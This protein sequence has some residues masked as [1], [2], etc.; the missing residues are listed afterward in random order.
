M[1]AELRENIKNFLLN[2]DLC[3]M[4]VLRYLGEKQQE[5]Y[6]KLFEEW[7]HPHEPQRKRVQRTT[8]PSCL[9]ILDPG[10]I[11]E[12]FET[13]ADAVALSSCTFDDFLLS[14][15]VPAVTLIRQRLVYLQLKSKFEYNF[16]EDSLATVKDCVKYVI[17]SL[18]EDEFKVQ[19]CPAASFQVNIVLKGEFREAEHQAIVKLSAKPKKKYKRNQKEEQEFSTKAITAFLQETSDEDFIREFKF[20]PE[21]TSSPDA[22]TATCGHNQIYFAGRYCKFSRELSQ[23]PW[24]IDGARRMKDSVEELITNVVKR[25]VRCGRITFSSSGREDVDVR[26][27]G[28]GRPFLLEVWS[29]KRIEWSAE[30]CAEIEEEINSSTSDISVNRFQ[31]INREQIK[32]L[33]TGEENKRKFYC[34]YCVT[35]KDTSTVDFSKL[36]SID[37][38]VLKQNTP[39]RVLHRRTAMVRER[40]IHSASVEIQDANHFKLTVCTQAGTYVK[41]FVHGDMGRTLPNVRTILAEQVDIEALDVTHVDL[42]WPPDRVAATSQQQKPPEPTQQQN[43]PEQIQAPRQL[44][45]P[46]VMNGHSALV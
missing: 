28:E 31:L 11:F 10:F 9:G 7:Q 19:F 16:S 41:E 35:A 38:V 37:N 5:V 12:T 22:A 30:E 1:Y 36:T 4:C 44:Q 34:A 17:G 3:S 43:R 2:H 20:P 27:L 24:I 8:C 26:M 21:S 18:F 23:T 32:D 13:V 40:T 6:C 46:V 15:S 39:M 29:P 25:F 14:I 42:D 45:Q 33:K